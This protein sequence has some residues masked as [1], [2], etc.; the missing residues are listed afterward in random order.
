MVDETTIESALRGLGLEF[1]R[2]E[3]KTRPR[4]AHWHARKKG[5]AGT[6]E[7]TLDSGIVTFSVRS[8]RTGD[9]TETALE[10]L[11]TLFGPQK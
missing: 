11:I 2:I 7:A 8:N 1:Q 4:A 6:L 3:L 9:W 5:M 10:H